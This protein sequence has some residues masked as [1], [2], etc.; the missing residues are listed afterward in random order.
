MKF[1]KKTIKALTR[2]SCKEP[3]EQVLKYHSPPF[4][5]EN[6]HPRTWLFYVHID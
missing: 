5:S 3:L 2:K 1:C 6:Q 4:S